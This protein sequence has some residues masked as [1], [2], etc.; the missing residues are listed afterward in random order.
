ME[1]NKIIN[2][3]KVKCADCGEFFANRLHIK[4]VVQYLGKDDVRYSFLCRDCAEK[5]KQ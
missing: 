5:V 4:A 3:H 1:I 2:I